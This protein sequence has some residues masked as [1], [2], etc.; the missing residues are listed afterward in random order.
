[1]GID[2]SR[3]IRHKWRI[4]EKTLFGICILGGGIGSWLG[5]YTFRHK[6]RHWYFVIGIPFITIAEIAGV[7]KFFIMG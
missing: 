5:M 1:M 3:A 7:V 4:P 6:T 2:K